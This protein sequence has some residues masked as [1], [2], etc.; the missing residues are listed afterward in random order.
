[1][2][3]VLV[4][5]YVLA[6]VRSKPSLRN[7][8]YSCESLFFFLIRGLNKKW[9]CGVQS[10]KLVFNGFLRRVV[11]AIVIVVVVVVVVDVSGRVVAFGL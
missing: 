1:M 9:V 7:G 4:R 8:V 6:D 10:L 2:S 11:V 3:L 5:T